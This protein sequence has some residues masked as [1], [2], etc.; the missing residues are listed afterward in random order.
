MRTARSRFLLALLA[1][2]LAS[3][4]AP[5]TE[6]VKLFEDRSS[7]RDS[8]T[9]LLVVDIASDSELRRELE[10]AL[11][12]RLKRTGVDAV[13]SY[14]RLKNHDGLS[15]VDIDR[16]GIDVGADGI[17][18]THM[19]SLETAVERKQGREDVIRTCRGGDPVDYFLYDN[20]I[21][22]EP[23]SVE[24]ALTVVVVSNLYDADSGDR[25]W[26][27]QSTCFRKENL[28]EVFLDEAEAIVR[29]LRIDGLI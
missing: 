7:A 16:T 3:G 18:I 11:V 23:D 13:A 1:T 2:A 9:R 29:Q 10:T 21:L 15:Q 12:S 6:T 28:R 19:V 5:Q 14:T 20:K 26:T 22:R 4:C 8:Y 24:L 25:I 17:L 27:I